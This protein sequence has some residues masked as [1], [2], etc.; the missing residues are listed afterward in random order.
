MATKIVR[1]TRHQAEEVQIEDLRRIFGEI[2]VSMVSETMPTDTRQFT[3]R[4]DAIA[5]DADVVEA[6]LPINLMEAALRFTA[7]A[8]RN[9]KLVRAMT[10][11]VPRLDADGK[12]VMAD[13]P[14]GAPEPVFDFVFDHYE[15]V[16]KVEIVTE[17]L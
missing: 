12:Q 13:K 8:K 3:A 4:F 5:G 15:L 11:R 16:K 10:N 14:G 17:R 7:F 6:V 2:E 9:G 1:L